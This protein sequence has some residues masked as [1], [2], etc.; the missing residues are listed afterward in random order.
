ML[1]AMGAKTKRSK[2]KVIDS[3]FVDSYRTSTKQQAAE[4]VGAAFSQAMGQLDSQHCDTEM[5]KLR[6][7]IE[8][9]SAKNK[10]CRSKPRCKK[11]PTVMHRLRKQ[12]ALQLDDAA[13]RAALAKARKW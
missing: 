1:L 11:C 4:L 8:R 6:A 10:C 12:G 2:L 3:F 5:R 9:G 13:L 7:Q